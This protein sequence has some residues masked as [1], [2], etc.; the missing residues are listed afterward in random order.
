[1]PGLENGRCDP[2]DF[3][4]AGGIF[5]PSGKQHGLRNP[6]GPMAGD[7]RNLVV[8]PS[9]LSN[10]NTA[11]ARVKLEPGEQAALLKPG[12]TSLVIYAQTDDDRT[13][14]EGGA[15]PRIACGVIVAGPS[16]VAIQASTALAAQPPPPSSSSRPN[17]MASVLI[18]LGGIVLIGA[19]LAVR[20]QGRPSRDPFGECARPAK[21][22]KR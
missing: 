18:A 4:T 19:G 11:A 12:G 21:L 2:P 14:P 1:V 20:R 8:G 7:L 16:G 13:Q 17:A 9:G 6:D 15:G 5:N 22:G 3:A 10:Y